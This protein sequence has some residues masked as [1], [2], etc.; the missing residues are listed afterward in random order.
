[1]RLKKSTVL[2]VCSLVAGACSASGEVANSVPDPAV[3]T[4]VGSSET[5]DT[6]TATVAP[7]TAVPLLPTST[8]LSEPIDDAPDDLDSGEALEPA[9]VKEWFPGVYLPRH[10]GL[11]GTEFVDLTDIWRRIRVSCRPHDGMGG[12]R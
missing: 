12:N 7:S 3:T 8:L 5:G 10:C 11:S 2:L 6:P 9:E 1:M 4:L